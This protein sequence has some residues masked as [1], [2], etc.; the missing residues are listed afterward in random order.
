MNRETNS[1]EAWVAEMI[2]VGNR[3][4]RE[5]QAENRALG[6]PNWYCLNG[7]R[8]SD[9]GEVEELPDLRGRD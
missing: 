6:I 2:R 7:R 8:V 4:V 1:H 3:A 9:I 5:A